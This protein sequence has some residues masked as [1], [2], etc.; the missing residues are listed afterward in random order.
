MAVGVHNF[1]DFP[2]LSGVRI[3]VVEA[4]IK[5]QSRK[6]LVLFEFD[7]S[8][9]VAG[10]FTKN[11]FCAAPV[12][13]SKTHLAFINERG[14]KAYFLINTGNANAGTGKQGFDDALQCCESLAQQVGCEQQRILPF[15]T[16]VIGEKLP[17]DKICNALTELTKSL[18]VNNWA[19]AAAGIMTTDTRP[20]GATTTVSYGGHSITIN[21][22]SKGAGMIKP[23]M[24]T[25]LCFVATDA[26]IPQPLLKRLVSEIAD[27]SFNRITIDGDTSTNDACMLVASG[28][29]LA[30]EIDE[31]HEDFQNFRRSL[32]QVFLDLSHAIVRDGEGATKF[33]T[34]RVE[35][36][37]SQQEALDV[38]YTIA[39]SPLVKTALFASDPNWGRIL[40]ALGRAPIV[41]FDLSLVSISLGDVMIVEGGGR[42][43]SY[44]EERGQTVM[45][46]EEITI[47]VNLDRGASVET[48]WTTD[49]SHDYVTINAEY[50]T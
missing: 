14:G 49:L 25:M 47:I 18:S 12:H 1:P 44:T 15:S 11:A 35:R 23:N 43:E 39:H 36:A 10:V 46:Q 13:I 40:A 38:G 3:G 28:A 17:V 34:I 16:G 48:I 26:S 27:C 4:G 20:K 5:K 31:S 9:N 33:V 19:D 6:D 7:A 32:Q 21:G 42:A 45:D 41:D 37:R 2:E 22:I 50:R 29:S 30:P 24:A 8:A